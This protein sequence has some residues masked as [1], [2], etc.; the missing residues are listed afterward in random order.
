MTR[1]EFIAKATLKHGDK[2]DYSKVEYKNN[3]TKV[4]ITC[5]IHGEFWQTPSGHIGGNN[6]PNCCKNKKMTTKDFI[7]KAICIHGSE[8]DYSKVN[9]INTGTKVCIICPAHGEFYQTPENHLQGFKCSKCAGNF[10]DNDY[11]IE[12]S[13][14]KHNNKYDYSK[15]KYIDINTDVIIKCPI[16]G[17]FKHK[18]HYHLRGSG[19][20]KCVNQY[21]DLDY[22][23]EK[24]KIIHGNKFDYSKVV[25]KNTLTKVCIICP[26]HGEFNQTAGS[27]LNGNGCPKCKQSKGERQIENVLNKYNIENIHNHKFDECKDKRKLPFDFYLP[28]M[29]TCIEYDGGQHFYSVDWFGGSD[30]FI[31]RQRRDN[32]KT[33]YCKDNDIEM[34]RI[35]YLD[36]NEIENILIK[37]LKL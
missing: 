11:F 12:L 23:I 10:M 33:K 3:K 16:H 24:S 28:F 14:V 19:C 22:F 37:K 35:S 17:D 5:P 2:Y 4:S 25:Y 9:Y 30:E 20:L 13:N 36:F 32:I 15:V 27:H 34:I 31:N 7:D 29:S 1:D 21:M 8:Y 18:P 6:C 26:V